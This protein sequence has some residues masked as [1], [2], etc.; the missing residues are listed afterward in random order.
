MVF[1]LMGRIAVLRD[2]HKKY[3]DI[4]AL[5]GV[6]LEIN[7]GEIVGLVGPNGSGKSTLIKILLGVLRRDKG[8]VLLN[9]Y[10]PFLDSRARVGVGVVMERPSLP[11]GISIRRF[12][13]LS[14]K[15]QGSDIEGVKRAIELTGLK[16]HEEK[17]FASLSAGL[18]QRAAIANAL[19]HRPFFI[20]ADEPTSNLDP[21]ERKRILE[22]FGQINRDEKIS[23]IISSHIL[24]EVSRVSNKIIVLN[25]GRVIASGSAGDILSLGGAA[26]IRCDCPD[27]L[28]SYLA[29]RGYLVTVE[30]GNVLVFL[31]RSNRTP[32][33]LLNDL[34]IFVSRGATVYSL[35]FV[36]ASIEELLGGDTK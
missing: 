34:S 1:S 22:L 15:I 14:A 24:P 10:D 26:R 31:S 13:E 29:N 9:G 20:V 6:S 2:V 28:S 5:N 12:L 18:K 21:V 19:V 4:K 35:D 36:G 32:G 16:G 25:N 7:S 23:F 3:G 8:D 33:D 27:E 17:P 11:D 30:T